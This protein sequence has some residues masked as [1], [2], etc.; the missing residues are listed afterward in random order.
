MRRSLLIPDPRVFEKALVNFSEIHHDLWY[1][2][3][4]YIPGRARAKVF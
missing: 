1:V 4:R 2:A 3:A